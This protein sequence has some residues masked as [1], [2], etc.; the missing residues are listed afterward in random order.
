MKNFL[1]FWKINIAMEIEILKKVV[2]DDFILRR[3][4]RFEEIM[5][6]FLKL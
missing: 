5:E 6:I 3:Y 1:F 4:L 2:N